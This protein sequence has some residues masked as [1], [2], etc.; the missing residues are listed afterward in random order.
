MKA[1]AT[2]I[3]AAL[4]LSTG[5]LAHA[6]VVYDES[7]NGDASS[8]AGPAFVGANVGTLAFGTSSILGRSGGS[9][10]DDYIFTIAPGTQLLSATITLLDGFLFF[11]ADL[12]TQAGLVVS[13]DGV[14]GTTTNGPGVF[15][16]FSDAMPLGPGTYRIDNNNTT[17][18]GTFGYRW[19][20]VVGT[21]PTPGTLALS[22]LALTLA[23]C[24]R[25]RL[26]RIKA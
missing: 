9:D 2:S 11:G 13:G 19:D 10:F 21:V 20:L 12:F 25:R 16:Q 3:A 22:A 23:A 17:T 26:P 14:G 4:L 1:F 7:V 5:C 24:G 15:A 6:A 18:P 8:T